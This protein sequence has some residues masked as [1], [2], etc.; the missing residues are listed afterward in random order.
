MWRPRDASPKVASRGRS[1]WPPH[2]SRT[3]CHIQLP[4]YL[5]TL[6]LAHTFALYTH[7]LALHSCSSTHPCFPLALP[8]TLA[9][10]NLVSSEDSSKSAFIFSFFL[11]GRRS[12]GFGREEESIVWISRGREPTF[13]TPNPQPESS[14]VPTRFHLNGFALW[15]FCIVHC[16]LFPLWIVW[17]VNCLHC[18]LWI[19]YIVCIVYIVYIVCIVC[20]LVCLHES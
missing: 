20:I 12:S 19:V 7:A 11:R 9:L 6:A 5:S 10:H 14:G 17:I 16:G 3:P 18:A 1:E 4:P 2:S 8:L 13:A 15:I